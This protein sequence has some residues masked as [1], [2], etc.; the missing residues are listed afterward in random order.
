MAFENE[1]VSFLYV[2][3]CFVDGTQHV[4]RF[5]QLPGLLTVWVLGY[6]GR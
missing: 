1:F 6:C 2:S 4:C 3:S 5:L